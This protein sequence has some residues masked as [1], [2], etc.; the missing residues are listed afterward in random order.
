MNTK[1]LWK[2][3]KPGDYTPLFIN[4]P[5]L[6]RPERELVAEHL[7][8]YDHGASSSPTSTP[9]TSSTDKFVRTWN[10]ESG[11][12]DFMLKGHTS[13]IEAMAFLPNVDAVGLSEANQRLLKQR[14]AKDGLETIDNTL[15]ERQ[16][17]SQ[18]D[19]S[20]EGWGTITFFISYPSRCT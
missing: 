5:A 2:E 19:Y 14:G 7:R 13:N 20:D 16:D 18:D 12:I 17:E 10:A 1:Q 9:P 15:D 11:A 3:Y 8:K 4:L 6:E